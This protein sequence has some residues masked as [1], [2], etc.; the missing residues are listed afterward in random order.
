M[1]KRQRIR[2]APDAFAD[3][4][5][6]FW[7]ASAPPAADDRA[8]IVDAIETIFDRALIYIGMGGALVVQTTVNADFGDRIDVELLL[9]CAEERLESVGKFESTDDIDGSDVAAIAADYLQYRR[10][11]T[12]IIDQLP[13]LDAAAPDGE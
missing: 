5:G 7:S 3:G 4:A 6:P 13:P 2:F 9:D 12:N 8:G 1:T 11:F 10:Y